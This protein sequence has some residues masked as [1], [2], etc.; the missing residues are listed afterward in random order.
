MQR[1][2][3]SLIKSVTVKSNSAARSQGRTRNGCV[4]AKQTQS[5]GEQRK[6]KNFFWRQ[7]KTVASLFGLDF[8]DDGI[9]TSIKHPF[10][11]NAI[12]ATKQN[13]CGVAIIAFQYN[14]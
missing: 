2:L 11:V 4:N 10:K 13:N 6:L 7:W 12:V 1:I 9:P 8:K 3:E 14:I 5:G